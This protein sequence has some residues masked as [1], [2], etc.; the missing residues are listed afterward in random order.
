ML[1]ALIPIIFFSIPAAIVGGGFIEE[2][3][4]IQLKKG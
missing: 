1:F 2:V 4:V 3:I